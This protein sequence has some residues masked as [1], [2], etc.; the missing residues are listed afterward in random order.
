MLWSAFGTTDIAALSQAASGGL[1]MPAQIGVALL[2]LA[3]ALKTAT[4]PLHGWLTEVMEAPTPVSAL[5]HA[6]I[7][8]GGGFLLIRLSDLVQ[9]RP[10]A[11]AALVMLG[12]L[13]ALF[14]AT[15]MLTQVP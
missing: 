6:G 3:A 1:P 7:I 15:V 4:F 14:G 2:V 8:N 12:G 11:M 5:M 9:A 13:T 10:G